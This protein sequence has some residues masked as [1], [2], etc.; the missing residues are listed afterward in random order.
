MSLLTSAATGVKGGCA[1]LNVVSEIQRR[2][3]RRLSIPVAAE[4]TT[5]G[6]FFSIGGE[7]NE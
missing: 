1:A 3:P 7:E 2:R 4:V 5:L 6:N